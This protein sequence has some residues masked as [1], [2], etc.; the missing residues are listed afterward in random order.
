MAIAMRGLKIKHTIR[1]TDL[2]SNIR[3]FRTNQ[4]PNRDAKVL[5]EGLF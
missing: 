1:A 4:T 3:W 2:S 5:R